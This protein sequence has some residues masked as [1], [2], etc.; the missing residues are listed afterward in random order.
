VGTL[1][2]GQSTQ[3]IRTSEVLLVLEDLQV[4]GEAKLISHELQIEN[5]W[6]MKLIRHYILTTKKI[7]YQFNSKT[8]LGTRIGRKRMSCSSKNKGSQDYLET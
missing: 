4:K 5:K 1:R 6:G 2:K 7:T 3:T 8:Y